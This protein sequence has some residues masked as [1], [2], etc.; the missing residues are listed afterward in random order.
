MFNVMR[1]HTN[2]MML[3]RQHFVHIDVYMRYIAEKYR[4]AQLVLTNGIAN[5]HLTFYLLGVGGKGFPTLCHQT[6]SLQ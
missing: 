2:V 5:R 4:E 6:S 3:E 1:I